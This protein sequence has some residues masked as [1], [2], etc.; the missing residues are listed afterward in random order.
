MEKMTFDKE[1]A[2]LSREAANN[3][4]F[5][6]GIT[7]DQQSARID[8][9]L[10]PKDE[11]YKASETLLYCKPLFWN[12]EQT[13]KLEKRIHEGNKAKDI[14]TNSCV[15]PKDNVT[16]LTSKISDGNSASWVYVQTNLGLAVSMVKK[17]ERR[18]DGMQGFTFDLIQ[19]TAIEMYEAAQKF[20]AD[21]GNKLS[22][23]V[24]LYL[25]GR[26]YRNAKKYLTSFN[27]SEEKLK[28]YYERKYD[29]LDYKNLTEL[30]QLDAPVIEN[31]EE[32]SCYETI[33]DVT[34]ED[35]EKNI[36]RKS[37]NR[38]LWDVVEKVLNDNYSKEMVQMYYDIVFKRK[39]NEDYSKELSVSE[40]TI[41]YRI[42]KMSE[43]I[44]NAMRS[45]NGWCGIDLI[46]DPENH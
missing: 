9:F 42:K 15:M 20:D 10:S 38:W 19:D 40:G 7:V 35:P 8:K 26:L 23:F 44:Q 34:T 24:T 39:S 37:F 14:L 17:F 2:I 45:Q 29:T 13:E 41:R 16:D 3:E 32:L 30:K 5:A 22:T 33:E 18:H 11:S 31:E 21:K 43:K 27:V 4:L 1:I 36:S 28:K 12:N 25:K 6:A 46:D